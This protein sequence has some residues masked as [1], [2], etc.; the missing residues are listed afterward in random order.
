MPFKVEVQT[1]ATGKWY[2]N[3]LEFA[4]EAEAETYGH[5]LSARWMLVQRFRIVE[6][7]P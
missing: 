2:S 5:D 7:T 1:D 3:G 4:T 6:A